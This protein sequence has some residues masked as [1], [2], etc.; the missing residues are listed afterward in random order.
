MLQQDIGY[1]QGLCRWQLEEHLHPLALVHPLHAQLTP[2]N[3]ALLQHRYRSSPLVVGGLVLLWDVIVLWQ[4]QLN[5]QCNEM[6]TH[7][8]CQPVPSGNAFIFFLFKIWSKVF[9]IRQWDVHVAKGR[10]AKASFRNDWIFGCLRNCQGVISA[11][12]WSRLDSRWKLYV[13]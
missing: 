9:L 8:P 13:K 12:S 6:E 5:T 2:N 4:L 1:S 11:R 3:Q 7:L 10:K